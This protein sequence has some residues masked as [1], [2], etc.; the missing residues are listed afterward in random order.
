MIIVLFSAVMGIIM[1][2]MIVVWFMEIF[3]N[4]QQWDEDFLSVQACC[5]LRTCAL[6]QY[7]QVHLVFCF[8]AWLCVGE[9][10]N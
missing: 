1:E 9:P 8:L 5:S 7:Y 2:E 6:N 4:R 10:K 3:C